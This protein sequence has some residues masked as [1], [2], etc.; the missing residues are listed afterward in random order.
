MLVCPANE[1]AK[2]ANQAN[3]EDSSCH[4]CVVVVLIR[5]LMFSHQQSLR[6]SLTE[7]QDSAMALH[8]ILVLLFQQE[9]GAIVHVPG[10]FI[11]TLISFLCQHLPRKEHEKL[12][13]CQH[14]ITVKWKSRQ[15]TSNAKIRTP[16]SGCAA[17][18]GA[19]D[20][21]KVHAT[22]EESS[23]DDTIEALIQDLKQL[24]LKVSA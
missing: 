9:T 16:E 5:Q 21:G 13:E 12:V 8:L 6:K 24:V 15:L 2:T 22:A 23:E 7:E 3:T 19:S 14:L 17:S 4:S 1:L 20:G 18:D 10:K 11:P